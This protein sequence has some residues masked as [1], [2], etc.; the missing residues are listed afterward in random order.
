RQA[1][2]E[3]SRRV[4]QDAQ[5]AQAMQQR[6]E[7]ETARLKAA[8]AEEAQRKAD[9]E[10]AEKKRLDDAAQQKADAD[11]AEKERNDEV[12]RQKA[13]SDARRKT[14][15]DERKVAEATETALRLGQ[16][17][18]QKIQVALTSVG[19]DTR[20]AD[21][22]LGART[23]E[24]IA[25]WQRSRG[26]P[27]T[28]YLTAAQQQALLREASAAVSKFDDDE[29]KKADEAKA[30]AAPPSA[31]ASPPVPPA[32]PPA[33][34]FNGLY[35]GSLSS[36]TPSGGQSALRPLAMELRIAGGQVTG[37]MV[38]YECGAVPI[39]LAVAPSGAISGNLRMYEGNCSPVNASA[40]GRVSGNTLMLEIRGMI[41]SARGSLT[42]RDE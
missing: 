42:R 16:P 14:E 26:H 34:G 4:A 22:A 17:D 8:A 40:S 33:A 39:S 30:R 2:E 27:A 6:A 32:T 31:L 1:A 28:G 38:N 25:S 12:A 24:M 10:A 20:G 23:R 37:E 21:G 18:R 29:R 13:E 19:F 7:A 9:A 35:A 15:D 5:G 11:A 3:E 36:S 41:R